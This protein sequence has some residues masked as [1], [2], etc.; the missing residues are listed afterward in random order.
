MIRLAAILWC[1]VVAG[2]SAAPA[3]DLQSVDPGTEVTLA[4]GA[5]VALKTGEVKV[6]FVAVTEDSRCPRDVN[7]IWAGQVKVRL[8]IHE[9]GKV[10]SRVEILEGG[11]AGVG[12]YRVTLL[13]VEPQPT[14]KARI[15]AQEYRATLKIDRALTG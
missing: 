12:E 4:P 7:C 8:E 15:A 10:M 13:R 14:S 1:L 6:R 2:C 5:T 9:A 3:R 11:N